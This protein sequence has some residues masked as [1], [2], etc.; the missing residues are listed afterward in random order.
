AIVPVALSPGRLGQRCR[1]R[2]DGRARGHVREALDRERGAL[3]R[4][5][6]A[7]IGPARTPEPRSPVAGSRGEARVGVV[8]VGGRL[9]LARPG[10]RTED[11][12]ALFEDMPG[13][14]PIALDANGHVGL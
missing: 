7:M 13:S 12:L 6:P 4:L 11:L 14:D 10:K 9:Q 8:D 3:D 2:G 1:Q 5:A